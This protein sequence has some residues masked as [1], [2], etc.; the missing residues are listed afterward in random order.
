[1]KGCTFR[2]ALT[3]ETHTRG[4]R[5][6]QKPIQDRFHDIQKK[7]SERLQKLR[8]EAEESN[9]D[10][11]FAPKLNKRSEQLVEKKRIQKGELP[12]TERLVKDA[13]NRIEKNYKNADV[14]ANEESM[15]Y[16]FRPQLSV[17]SMGLGYKNRSQILSS[18]K[19]FLERQEE[20]E[21]KV[22]Q[23]KQLRE[24][25]YIEDTGCT[26][27]P[28]INLTSEIMVESD[29]KRMAENLD[30][31]VN[32]LSKKD[33]KRN[34]IMREMMEKKYS[35]QPN[36]NKVSKALAKDKSLTDLAYDPKT[37]EHK[38]ML[39]QVYIY[40]YIYNNIYIANERDGKGRMYF[41]TRL[42]Q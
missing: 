30:E 31:K 15:N 27:Q 11:K 19:D 33:A 36:I 24:A 39:V 17:S 22:R 34:Q 41:P 25:E 20:Y 16:P 7:K 35:F 14:I 28:E 8:M 37:K 13:V 29:P 9:P 5:I 6:T 21:Q 26:F 1:M 23:N 32:R 4:A 40:I 10:L 3:E 2:P 12:V 38:E 42:I 18:G